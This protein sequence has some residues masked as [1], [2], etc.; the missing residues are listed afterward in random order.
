MVMGQNQP[1]K[2]VD[3]LPANEFYNLEGKQFSKSEGWYIDLEDFFKRYTTDQI[4]YAIASNAP[5]TSDSE[6]SWKDFQHRCNAELLG[7]YG[8]LVNRVLVF[9]SNRMGGLAPELKELELIDHEFLR[10]IRSIV[11][12]TAE[13]YEQFKLRKASS[14]VMELTQLGNVY[15]DSK[16]PWLDAKNEAYRDRL[17]TTLA[18]CLEC[19]KALALISYPIIPNAACRVWKMLGFIESIEEKGWENILNEK[20][21]NGQPIPTPTVLFQKIEDCQVEQE[22]EKLHHLSRKSKESQLRKPVPPKEAVS[23]DL[24]RKL[25]LRVGVILS[26]EKVP[27]SKKL[28]RLIVDIG[29]EKRTIVSGLGECYQPEELIGKQVIVVANLESATLMGVKSEGMLLAANDGGRFELVR[30]ENASP[31]SEVT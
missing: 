3:E 27:K 29:I 18:C 23:I 13:C 28:L 12:Q 14:Y 20:F 25:D 7:K 10:N 1:Y 26:A 17:N 4:R 24:V 5:E 11:A 8:N 9:I 22:I 2:L 19:L 15:F 30:T 16:H 6:F 31:G 21:P